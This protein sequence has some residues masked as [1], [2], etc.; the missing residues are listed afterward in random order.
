VSKNNK[1]M[2]LEPN[3]VKELRAE[4][5]WSQEILAEV[6]EVSLRTIQRAENDLKSS[7]ETVKAIASVFEIDFKNLLE[8]EESIRVTEIEFLTRIEKGKDLATL[9]NST[10][11]F[12]LDFDSEVESEEEISFV[13]AFFQEMQDYSDIWDDIDSGGK[14]KATITFSN[15]IQDLE[16]KHLWVFAGK[17]QQTQDSFNPPLIFN[18]LTLRVFKSDNAQIIKINIGGDFLTEKSNSSQ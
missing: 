16:A 1:K 18:I 4:K 13:H 7:I 14:G 8:P 5:G 10:H 17:Y 12:D 6:A 2:N 9:I 15:W 11:A 3:K